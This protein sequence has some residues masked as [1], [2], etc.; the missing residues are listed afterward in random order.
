MKTALGCAVLAGILAMS[1]PGTRGEDAP[2]PSAF[3]G[4]VGF[5]VDTPAGRSGRV[6]RVT[7]LEREGPGSLREALEAAG[8]R[9]VVFEVGGIIDLQTRGLTIREPFVTVAGETAPSP[10]ITLIRGG[11]G[12]ATHDV[13]IRHLRVRPGDA[14]RPKK[15]GWEPDGITAY[16]GNAYNVVIDHCSVTWAVDENISASGARTEGPTMTAHRVTISNCIIAEG[17]HD[18]SHKKGPH[19]KGSLI[20]DFCRDIAVISNLYAH[21]DRRNPFFKAHAT[22]VVANNVIYNPG[23]AAIQM[24]WAAR[25]WRKTEMKPANS[26]IAAVGNVFFHGADTKS[27]LALIARQ[28]DAYMAD[29]VALDRAGKSVPLTQ[30]RIVMLAKPPLWPEGFE[31]LPADQV[32]AHVTKHVGAR[33]RDRDDVDRRIIRQFV[34]REGKIIDSQDEVGGYPEMPMARRVLDVPDA[35]IDAW[36]AKMA[37]EVE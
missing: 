10:G 14:G 11:L 29:N 34:A 5:G 2:K 16:S 18:S 6:L 15:S 19:S 36:L 35:G 32:V 1:V 28:G 30:G 7:A 17:L 31:A 27:G 12:I 24:S 23:S 22:G 21:N 9:I 33:P 8:P 25:E 20:H 13:L 3:P 26:R 37:A 4:A